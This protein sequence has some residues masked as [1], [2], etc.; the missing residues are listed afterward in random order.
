MAW[1]SRNWQGIVLL[2]TLTS[3]TSGLIVMCPWTRSSR[4]VVYCVYVEQICGKV[5]AKPKPVLSFIEA[6]HVLESMRAFLYAHSITGRYQV[7]IMNIL[8]L[9]VLLHK[10]SWSLKKKSWDWN[11]QWEKYH[12]YML[13][14]LVNM[15]AHPTSIVFR[16]HS[17]LLGLPTKITNQ[18]FTLGLN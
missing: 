9:E 18:G 1:F 8:N 5:E 2:W 3:S 15:Q 6:L 13:F 7:N 11:W 4:R 16:I 17:F 10:W 12:W 14:G